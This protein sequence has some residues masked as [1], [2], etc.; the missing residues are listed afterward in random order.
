MFHVPHSTLSDGGGS[1]TGRMGEGEVGVRLV[2]M[3]KTAIVV[4]LMEGGGGG[5]GCV[6]L[7]HRV[8]LARRVLNQCAHWQSAAEERGEMTLLTPLRIPMRCVADVPVRSC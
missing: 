6:L 3:T 5:G 2:L 8:S 7:A 1:A 4:V